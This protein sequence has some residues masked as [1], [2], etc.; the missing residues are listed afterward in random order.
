MDSKFNARAIAAE[1]APDARRHVDGEDI[2]LRKALDQPFRH[3]AFAA[4]HFKNAR[5]RAAPVFKLVGERFNI[6]EH[7]AIERRH[8]VFVLA[9]QPAH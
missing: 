8:P 6:N 4:S 7:A 3:R 1:K 9:E 2:G 5:G